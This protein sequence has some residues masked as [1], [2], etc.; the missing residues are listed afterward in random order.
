MMK[1]K[2]LLIPILLVVMILPII[3]LAKTCDSNSIKIESINVKEKS[4]KVIENEKAKIIGNSINLNVYLIDVGDSISYD[5]IIKNTSEE[6]LELDTNNISISSDYVEYNVVSSDNSNVVPANSSKTMTVKIKYNN[7]V[8]DSSYQDGKYND[9]KIMTLNI[10]N[11]N[12]NNPFTNDLVFIYLLLFYI[13]LFVF[14]VLFKKQKKVI[15]PIAVAILSIPFSINALCK[16]ELT[17]NSKILIE[18]NPMI[19]F[20]Y[21]CSNDRFNFYDGMTFAEWFKSDLYKGNIKGEFT[22]IEKCEKVLGT[23]RGCSVVRSEDLYAVHGTYEEIYRTK[24]ECIY[25]ENCVELDN[26]IYEIIYALDEYDTLEECEYVHGADYCTKVN[27]KYMSLSALLEEDD[28]TCQMD[29]S[30]GFYKYRECNLLPKVYKET[31][32]V[33]N[34]Y[35][36][37]EECESYYGDEGMCVPTTV[38]YASPTETPATEDYK[39]TMYFKDDHF[40][41][42]YSDWCPTETRY[43][44]YIEPKS[45]YCDAGAECVSPESNIL[46]ANNTTIKAKNIKENDKIAYYD[47]NTNKIEIGTVTKVYIHK[48]A[49]NL[50]RYTLSDNTYLEVTDYHPIYTK[51]GWKSY[52]GRNGYAKPVI[53]DQVKT[54]NG[55]KSIIKIT[56]FNGREDY[57]DFQIKGQDGKLVN[58]YYANGILVEGTY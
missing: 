25:E 47:F 32:D 5:M 18:K 35:D 49:T 40:E 26:Q 34:Y 11:D 10:S 52:T 24:K 43:N 2:K 23:N 17:I 33:Y 37:L 55:Y 14:I 38:H 20:E 22:S 48:D 39:G 53:G 28:Y 8:N 1:C 27:N 15:V 56:L 31:I 46:S 51:S 45:Y 21:R 54:S 44:E 16:S 7:K 36:D 19:S 50:I 41:Y 4:G 12:T 30:D 58:N 6:D 9:N 29:N 42:L 13:S 3:V 57:Y